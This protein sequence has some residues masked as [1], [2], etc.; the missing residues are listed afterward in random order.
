[1]T[2]IRGTNVIAPIVPFATDDEYPSHEAAYGRGGYRTVATTA[3]RDAIPALRREAGMLVCVT[4]GGKIWKLGTDLS[5]WTEF[6][7][8]SNWADITGK[9]ATFP[10][11]AHTH[12]SA[13]ITDFA[14]AVAAVATGSGSATT[15]AS[16][17]TSG[18]L[19]IARLPAS[20]VLASD[21]RLS[22]ARTPLAHQQAISTV[23][24]L[25]TALDGKQAAGS[26]SAAVHTHTAS[27]VSGLAAV[28]TSGSYGDLS[29][30]PTIPAATTSASDLTSGS[31]S[32][33][34]LNFTPIHPFL[35]MGG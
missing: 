7:A 11:L 20:V 5:T 27:D 35:L 24:G 6:S 2:A 8:S 18:T 19:D 23:T 16:L 12:T 1:M 33:A 34:R 30:K 29:N 28:A 14:A 15:D 22:D 32:Q 13:S 9:P 21:G 17:L 25:Q 4:D 26:Y 31:L 10:P 3:Q